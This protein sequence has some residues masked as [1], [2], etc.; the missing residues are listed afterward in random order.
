MAGFTDFSGGYQQLSST[1]T[2]VTPHKT[3]LIFHL[4]SY[5]DKVRPVEQYNE[6]NSFEQCFGEDVDLDK[7]LEN[8][9][10]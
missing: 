5:Y 2:D 6:D 4:G 3:L 8:E 1:K 10:K 7:Y 9:I